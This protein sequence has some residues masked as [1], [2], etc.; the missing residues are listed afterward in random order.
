M[1]NFLIAFFGVYALAYSFP[2]II[3]LPLISLGS[4]K[5]IIYIDKQLAKD[6]NKYYN[7]YGYMLPKHQAP[8]DVGTRFIN[9]CVAYPFIRHRVK[10][11]S[12]KFKAFMWWNAG[13]MWSWII[14]FILIFI[15]KGLGISF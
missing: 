12:L 7:D 2:S 14:V 6:L 8:H 9:Y 1:I 4:F 10:T 11:D 15:E 3:I 5:Y 13:G